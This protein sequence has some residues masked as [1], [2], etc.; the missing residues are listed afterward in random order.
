MSYPYGNLRTGPLPTANNVSRKD[1]NRISRAGMD[2]DLQTPAV[3]TEEG[4][5]GKRVWRFQGLTDHSNT[6]PGFGSQNPHGASEL[7]ATPI[8]GA[9]MP[10]LCHSR[11]HHAHGRQTYMNAKHQDTFF[12]FSS[13]F[14]EEGLERWLRD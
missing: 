10:S 4:G 14:N 13:F 7:F 6:S 11:H 12:F 9:P 1:S 5:S 8:P 3:K 2:P